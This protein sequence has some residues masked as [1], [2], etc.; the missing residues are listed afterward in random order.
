M[1]FLED[2]EVQH[3]LGQAASMWICNECGR[4]TAKDY[5][6]SCDRVYWLHQPGCRMYDCHDGHRLTIVPFVEER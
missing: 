2:T 5:C 4:R 1:P 6:R 3:L